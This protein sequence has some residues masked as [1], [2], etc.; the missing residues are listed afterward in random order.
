MNKESYIKHKFEEIQIILSDKQV[1]QFLQF[2]DLLV[3]RNKV[4]NL[5]AITEFEEVVKK[6]FTDSLSV[7]KITD[8]KQ[9]HSII[10]V[11][12]GAGFPGI[13]IKIV[14]PHLDLILLD[15]LQKRIIFLEDVVK[16]T[17]LEKV[18]C[19]HGRAEDAA[20]KSDLREQ[21]DVCVSRAVADLS[22]LSEYCLP[23]IRPG[24]VFISYKSG[25]ADQEVI[26]ADNAINILGGK[27]AQKNLFSFL[28]R[29][30]AGCSLVLKRN[31]NHHKSILVSRDR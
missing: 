11:G 3:E 10:D 7:V 14:Y 17:E 18:T 19:I 13:P 22:V 15:S 5:T 12:T 29:I 6:H 30:L 4:M 28:E 26:N 27:I 31:I 21:I 20:K 23:F 1:R 8:M 9:Y 25:N 24:G 2:Y 16:Q